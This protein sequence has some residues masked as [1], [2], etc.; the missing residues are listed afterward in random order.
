MTQFLDR[1]NLIELVELVEPTG[2]ADYESMINAWR[3]HLPVSGVLPKHSYWQITYPISIPIMNTEVFLHELADSD[4]IY[5]VMARNIQGS[6]ENYTRGVGYFA[7]NALQV[8]ISEIVSAAS[9]HFPSRD[10]I[11]VKLGDSDDRKKHIRFDFAQTN[12]SLLLYSISGPNHKMTNLLGIPELRGRGELM[13]RA[14]L[15]PKF[16][17]PGFKPVEFY[18]RK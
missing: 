11:S 6:S 7:R 1:V 13:S 12:N 17:S 3:W 4:R 16:V 9:L 8:S 15:D 5:G 18:G 10:S 14:V 2:V